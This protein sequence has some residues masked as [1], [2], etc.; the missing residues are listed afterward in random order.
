[1]KTTLIY[2]FGLVGII[3]IV[4]TIPITSVNANEMEGVENNLHIET[5]KTT[6]EA[7][8][9][10]IPV[11][12]IINQPI[13]N[14]SI[15]LEKTIEE[16]IINLDEIDTAA[17]VEV[18]EEVESIELLDDYKTNDDV[19]A[20]NLSIWDSIANSA[21]YLKSKMNFLNA[22]TYQDRGFYGN[23]GLSYG[24]NIYNEPNNKR[25]QNDFMHKYKLGY[26]G[27]IYSP[28]LLDYKIETILKYTKTKTEVDNETN[29]IK[30]DSQDYRVDLSFFKESKIPF[31]IYANKV[32]NP[33]S[34]LYA[35]SVTE[36]INK[37]TNLGIS[38]S[39]KL[40]ILD[41]IYAASDSSGEYENI[42][43]SENREVR[44]YKGSIN[45]KREKS[46]FQLSYNNY[47][48]D[49][50]RTSL[51]S[52]NSSISSAQQNVDLIY[53]LKINKAIRLNTSAYYRIN[54]A[55]DSIGLENKTKTI[56][57][58]VNL[59]WNPNTK[60]RASVNVQGSKT[61][62]EMA[63]WNNSIENISVFQNYGY[64]MTKNLNITQSANYGIVYSGL[65]KMQNM[66]LSSGVSYS[67]I[68]N[69]DARI[70]L[71]SSVFVRNNSD[72]TNNTY[73]NNITSYSYD[74]QAGI[75]Q[76]MAFVNSNMNVR[77][78][79]YLSENTINEVTQRYNANL[80][81]NTSI[82]SVVKN[83]LATT[84][85]KDNTKLK[86]YDVIL[87][88]NSHRIDVEDKIEHNSRVGIKGMVKSNIGIRYSLL[89]SN[90]DKIDRLTP[91]VDILFN[92]RLGPRLRS[93]NNFHIDRELI[94]DTTNYSF[95][96]N[97]LFKS[98]K[99]TVSLVYNYNKMIINYDSEME[100]RSAHSVKMKFERSF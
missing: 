45:R 15:K 60:Y 93:T 88:R 54:E 43:Y 41:I 4:K 31:R 12:Y 18:D 36:S 6:S 66:S 58:N 87:I 42:Y 46:N 78:G 3:Y 49:I 80:S 7:D 47:V 75:N 24:Y 81:I 99:T 56:Y 96:S 71:S 95:M 82:Y 27:V 92:Y 26:R 68:L 84:Y 28:K 29:E 38:G 19:K 72:D 55:I 90:G 50:K 67:N 32:E 44:T 76:K 97:L 48:Q 13:T 86:S 57:S 64:R 34:V 77:I 98:R 11:K 70:N 100:D 94:N 21:Y 14:I 20:S 39:V 63:G 89:E 69:K 5:S 74:G 10:A 40:N 17:G 62:D 83:Y 16:D 8:T 65:N 61:E 25:Y 22:L 33:V 37:S 30:V 23:I 73:S 51:D 91:K 59:S 2:L 79:Y 85:Y 1:M 35:N 53:S 52:N 9:N